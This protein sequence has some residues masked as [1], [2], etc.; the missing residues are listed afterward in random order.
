MLCTIFCNFSDILKLY[1]NKVT[2]NGTKTL[3]NWSFKISLNMY[4]L[5]DPGISLLDI[6]PREMKTGGH[7][8]TCTEIFIAI[9]K[10]K[11]PKC[12]PTE[13]CMNTFDILITWKTT[14]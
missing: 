13:E 3:E 11:Q 6:Y 14:W 9:K 10:W 2:K 12:L 1:Q 7:R 5:Y 4:L 8:K